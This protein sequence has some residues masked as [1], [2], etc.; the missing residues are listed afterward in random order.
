MWGEGGSYSITMSKLYFFTLCSLKVNNSLKH[1]ISLS[2][3]PITPNEATDANAQAQNMKEEDF[4]V[5]LS[6]FS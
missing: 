2:L 3:K 1:L 6:K 4:F 5:P